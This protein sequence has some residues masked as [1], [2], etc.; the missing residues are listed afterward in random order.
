MG[1]NG[2]LLALALLGVPAADLLKDFDIHC[3]R[4]DDYAAPT[5]D[6]EVTEK[7]PG[8]KGQL[9]LVADP[10]EVVSL[11]MGY[12][13][14]RLL[15]VNRTNERAHV[16]GYGHLL[17][18]LIQEARDEHGQWRPIEKEGSS[19]FIDCPLRTLHLNP[20][21]YWELAAPRYVGPFKTK[22]RFRLRVW[23][24]DLDVIYS[25]EFDGSI[26]SD[27]FTKAPPKPQY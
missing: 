19:G 15:L 14:M 17:K 16:L 9:A 18:L 5:S 3:M 10:D 21:H 11:G 12:R 4:P 23:T 20:S 24:P 1:T 22:L 25:N 27:Q 6:K 7:T 26:D 8:T 2:L 13:G